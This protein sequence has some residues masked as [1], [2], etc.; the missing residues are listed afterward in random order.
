MGEEKLLSLHD[1]NDVSPFHTFSKLSFALLSSSIFS[2]LLIFFRIFY[3]L[4]V[5]YLY[6]IWNLFLAW[7]PVILA[8]VFFIL[9]QKRRQLPILM[10]GL[11]ISWLLFFPNAMYIVTDLIHLMTK[12]GVPLWYDVMVFFSFSWNGVILGLIS[13]FMI[14]EVLEQRFG[15]YLSWGAV[16]LITIASN[17][18]IYLGRFLRW[19]SWDIVTNPI[20]LLQDIIE[21][22]LSPLDFPKAFGFTAIYSLFFIFI[23]LQI[24]VIFKYMEYTFVK[25]KKSK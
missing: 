20:Q 8:L 25:L 11:F 13:L 1:F 16:L 24:R 7:I 19:N 6:L 18:G 10:A 9:N 3:Y 14:H 21:P 12:H 5:E 17:Y 23:Y 4:R 22:F 2:C 15:G